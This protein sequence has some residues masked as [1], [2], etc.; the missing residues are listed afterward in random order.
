EERDGVVVVP[1]EVRL[2][3][4]VR[5]RGGD[6]GAGDL[7]IAAGVRLGPVHLGALAAAGGTRVRCGRRPP[8]VL[9]VT[10][11]ERRSRG[12]SLGPGEIYDANGV[13]LATQIGSTGA[14]VERLPPVRDDE[15]ATRAAVERG[16]AADVLVTSGGVSVGVYD[17]VRATEAELGVEEV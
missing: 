11:S 3:A 16:L 10:G 1:G 13:I 2:G 8:V 6:L 9:A 12:E 7:V 14:E 5:R 15:E 17:L 4:N